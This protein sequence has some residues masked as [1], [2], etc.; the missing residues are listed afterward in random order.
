LTG[1]AAAGVDSDALPIVERVLPVFQ[2]AFFLANGGQRDL[3]TPVVADQE[4]P[5]RDSIALTTTY[6]ESAGGDLDS[7]LAPAG[8]MAQA[9]AIILKPYDKTR[10]EASADLGLA[11]DKA[12]LIASPS[13][14]A[15]V[16]L[17]LAKEMARGAGL[18]LAP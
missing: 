15:T 18:A 14:Q 3:A 10:P 6:R 4:I 1:A 9:R 16:F 12:E 17:A 11:L 13:T 8:D 7:A 2:L 5:R